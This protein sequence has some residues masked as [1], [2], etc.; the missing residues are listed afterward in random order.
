MPK[1]RLFIKMMLIYFFIAVST[2]A[3]LG[4]LLSFMLNNYLIYNKKMEMM[5]KANDISNLVKPYLVEKRDPSELINMLN[6]ADKNLGTEIWVIDSKGYVI[7]ASANQKSHEGNIIHP[8]DIIQMQ[9]GKVS[10]RQGKSRIYEETV[11]WVIIPVQSQEKVI[12][13]VIVYSPIIGITQTMSKVSNLFIYSAIVSMMFSAAVIYLLSKY[14]T[15]PLLEMNRVVKLLAGGKL[16]ERVWVRPGDEIG[17][18]GEAFNFMADR[19]EKNE[20]MRREFVADVSHELRSPLSNI[21]GYI[22]AM[23][24]G[25]DKTPEDRSRYL[26]IVHKE[27]M[28]LSRLVN[29]LLDLSRLESGPQN[30][31]NSSVEIVRVVKNSFTKFRHL[32]DEKGILTGLIVPEGEYEVMGNTDR[33]EQVLYNLFDNAMRFS[34]P[35]QKVT[36]RIETHQGEVSITVTDEG[37]GIPEEDLPHIWE[38]FYKVD[39]ARCREQGGT[40]LGLAIVKQTVQTMGGRV[41]AASRVGQGT[42]IGFILPVINSP[43]TE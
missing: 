26:G 18:L 23:M 38:R 28:R 5:V 32:F 7:A 43:Q 41:K 9:E 40:G 42:E 2:L 10:V 29:E 36:V 37:Q 30:I 21:Q 8:S 20:K 6:L 34:A 14:M 1:S 31:N 19:I 4:I 15:D 35:G 24:D 22:E 33:L 12:G 25:K 16:E 13:G 27:T 39:K 3:M 11:L 17:D